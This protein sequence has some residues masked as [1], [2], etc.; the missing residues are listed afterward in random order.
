MTMLVSQ[1]SRAGTKAQ[2]A[3]LVIRAAH[4]P[5]LPFRPA[6][7]DQLRSK[8]RVRLLRLAVVNAGQLLAEEALG[9]AVV[10]DGASSCLVDGR[11]QF[12]GC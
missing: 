6:K 7:L 2:H 9:A 4:R 3:Y 8:L 5:I 1:L 10:A 12:V 11:V